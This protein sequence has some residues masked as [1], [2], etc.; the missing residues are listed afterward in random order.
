MGALDLTAFDYALKTRYDDGDIMT[1]V[2]KENPA[3][4]RMPRD[5]KF[6]DR[7]FSFVIHY[8]ASNGRS[9]SFA[10]AQGN[11]TASK[12]IEVLIR[13]AHD[14]GIGRIDTETMLASEDDP[15]KMRQAVEVEGEQAM[16]ALANSLGRCTYGDGSGALGQVGNSDLDT[17]SM[18]LKDPMDVVHFEKDMKLVFAANRASALRDTGKVLTVSTVDEATGVVVLSAKLNT[19]T[20]LAQYDMIAVEGD[21]TAANDRLLPTGFDGW[22]PASAP[23][24]TESWLGGA[25]RRPHVVRLCG[26]RYTST[27]HPGLTT[28]EAATLLASRIKRSG[29]SADTA[30]IGTDRFRSLIGELD[31]KVVFDKEVVPL[32]NVDG[33]IVAEVG[34]DIVKVHCGGSI[35]KIFPDRNCPETTMHVQ[36]LS[37]WEFKSMGSVPRWVVKSVPVSDADQIEFRLAYWGQFRCKTPV[38][39]GRYDW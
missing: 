34:F 32:H 8:G 22:I 1:A 33:E 20:A 28:V 11:Y 36:T 25:D 26:H 27:T 16:I 7:N 6:P 18:T 39:N 19:V 38:A 35:L 23:S 29:F 24:G 2:C 12:G 31:S 5:T 14:Y 30:Y 10:K 3:F 15:D 17:T 13:R 9:A 4:A 37:S 21:Y